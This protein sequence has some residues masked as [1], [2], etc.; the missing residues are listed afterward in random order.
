MWLFMTAIELTFRLQFSINILNH[1]AQGW[2]LYSL[3]TWEVK[4]LS[5]WNLS[6]VAVSVKLQNYQK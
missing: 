3:T 2:K 5:L 4:H 1:T 6:C